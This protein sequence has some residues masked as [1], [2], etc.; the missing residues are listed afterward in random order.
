MNTAR[1]EPHPV[2]VHETQMRP[3]KRCSGHPHRFYVPPRSALPPFDKDIGSLSPEERERHLLET[4]K[5]I[6][7]KEDIFPVC[8]EEDGPA[9]PVERTTK[10]SGHEPC[11]FA[12]REA[13]ITS[14]K[15]SSGLTSPVKVLE[16]NN[17]PPVSAVCTCRH[18][19]SQQGIPGSRNGG[20]EV[21]KKTMFTA[22]QWD[23]G[24]YERA[25]RA[26]HTPS[27]NTL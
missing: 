20:V 23:C 19:A 5:A 18:A 27:E 14:W 8:I 17:L 26:L 24:Y 15:R 12:P 16:G 4:E 6:S 10:L 3:G 7:F 2:D 1:C 11:V 13:Y 25:C 22:K 9:T 21:L